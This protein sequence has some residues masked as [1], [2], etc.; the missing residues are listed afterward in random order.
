MF[1]SRSLRF[2]VHPMRTASQSHWHL[3]QCMCASFCERVC[4]LSVCVG[5]DQNEPPYVTS[6]L[7]VSIPEERPI[8]TSM[9]YLTVF[10]PD[11]GD[12]VTVV[13]LLTDNIA[14]GVA[15]AL[16]VNIS[17]AL[18]S[19]QFSSPAWGNLQVLLTLLGK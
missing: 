11:A 13:L 1:L 12:V 2:T 6:P 18:T 17:T 4:V 7:V 9:Y 15:P 3:I 10:D 19:A 5:L 16:G 14:N 8:N